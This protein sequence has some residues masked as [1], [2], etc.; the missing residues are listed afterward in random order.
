MNI[1]KYEGSF[2]FIKPWTAVRDSVTKSNH[3]LTPS[4]LMGIERKLFPELSLNDNGKLNK[5]SRYRLSFQ[6]ISFQ[7]ESTLA[8]NYVR[9]GNKKKG[10]HF[11]RKNGIVSRGLLINPVL[12]L[13][14]N[15]E[16]DIQSAKNEHICLCRNEDIMLPVD[17]IKTNEFDFDNDPD[18]SGYETFESNS[19]GI[20]CGYNKY[21]NKEQF[22]N[23]QMFGI[24]L[25]LRG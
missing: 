24:P 1:L 17:I 22:V 12:Y 23:L 4:I 20:Y 11:E 21:T 18:F 25:N 6:D 19:D 8:V 2:G 14:F 9:K 7:Q 16:I 3:Y 13:V 5:I 15:S 10:F